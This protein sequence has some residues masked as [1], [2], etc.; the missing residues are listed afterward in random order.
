MKNKIK[1][2]EMSK[3]KKLLHKK[4]NNLMENYSKTKKLF[5]KRIQK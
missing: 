5:E 1:S 2:E 3:D 4:I